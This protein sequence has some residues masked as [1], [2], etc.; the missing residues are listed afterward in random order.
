MGRIFVDKAPPLRHPIELGVLRGPGSPEPWRR[1]VI[2]VRFAY[3]SR[4]SFFSIESN[5]EL[6]LGEQTRENEGGKREKW[7]AGENRGK[8]W[9]VGGNRGVERKMGEVV[10]CVLLEQCINLLGLHGCV[11]PI[12]D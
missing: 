9:K 5:E 11:L 12:V 4:V 6:G 7:G 3:S 1:L 2:E 8:Q 10:V